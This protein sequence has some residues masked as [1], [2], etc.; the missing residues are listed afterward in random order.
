MNDTLT[1]TAGAAVAL[2]GL[3]RSYGQ[4]R[5]VD[6]ARL[7]GVSKTAASLALN[8]PPGSRLSAETVTRV[9]EAAQSLGYRPNPAARSLRLGTTRTVGVISDE[10]IITRY[11]SAM[12][13]GALDVAQE[14]DHTLLISEANGDP[15]RMAE[16]IEA[17]LDRHADG[18]LFAVMAAKLVELPPLPERL[19]VVLVNGTGTKGEPAVLPAEYEAGFGIAAELLQAGHRDVAIV[20]HP[21]DDRLRAEHTVTVGTRL[22][23][24]RAAFQQAGVEPALRLEA[25]QWEPDV[26]YELTRRVLAGGRPVTALLCM[27]D[28]LAFG[29]YQALQESGVGLLRPRD[30]HV[31]GHGAVEPRG[32]QQAQADGER[33]R[34][35][36]VQP[37]AAAAAAPGLPG[38]GSGFGCGGHRRA[39]PALAVV[40]SGVTGSECVI[41]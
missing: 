2:T 15:A 27:N 7:A 19:R 32:G 8:A 23:G 17:T 5:A 38:L 25:T 16:A 29:A 31:R 26:G 20:G 4:V 34:D 9:R 14:T 30:V 13:T 37:A 18:V 39:F 22:N 1:T 28:R 24:I 36:A 10:V 11:A 6:V 12:I 35:P 40:V 41:G 21:P 33:A 3:R